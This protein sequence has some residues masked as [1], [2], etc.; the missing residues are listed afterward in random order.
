MVTRLMTLRRQDFAKDVKENPLEMVWVHYELFL[1]S[2]PESFVCVARSVISRRRL[3]ERFTAG[4]NFPIWFGEAF[5]EQPDRDLCRLTLGNLYLYLY[6]V[7]VDDQLDDHLNSSQKATV[8]ANLHLA[9]SFRVLHEL[10]GEDEFFVNE[11]QAMR[12]AWLEHDRELVEQYKAGGH[13]A[14]HI[15]SYAKKCAILKASGLVLASRDR[16]FGK[17]AML[18]RAY[19]L[20]AIANTFADDL[21]DWKEDVRS[22]HRTYLIS[23]ALRESF[24]NP[25]QDLFSLPEE[26][27]ALLI[28]RSNAVGVSLQHALGFVEEAKALF[29][30]SG[31]HSWFDFVEDL[32]SSIIDVFKEW[33]EVRD[34]SAEEILEFD[35]SM[36]TKFCS[37]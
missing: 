21:T 36:K 8:V 23:T 30:S 17:W 22:N 13:E 4:L 1:K 28:Y 12:K 29:A 34:R 3:K 25:N 26:E 15:E 20:T 33:Q 32:E 16:D 24:L 19:D 18:S 6:V 14:P 27:M 31:A 11:F 35:V 7:I 5:T 10:C 9:E 37:T 2:L